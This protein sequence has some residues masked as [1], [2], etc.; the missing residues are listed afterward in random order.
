MRISDWSSDVCSSD[1]HRIGASYSQSFGEAFYAAIDVQ[2]SK[3]IDRGP[4]PLMIRGSFGWRLSPDLN[5]TGDLFHQRNVSRAGNESG[6][7]LSPTMRL[8]SHSSLHASYDSPSGPSRLSYQR[9]QGAGVGSY[10][11]GAG[12][13]RS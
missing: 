6:L 8:G 7:R 1:L 5:L 3:R 13:E 12:V 2:H 10:S 11:S 9:R 4:D